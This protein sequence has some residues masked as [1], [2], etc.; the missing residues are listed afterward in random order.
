M[1]EDRIQ[2]TEQDEQEESG[3]GA[4]EEGCGADE[5]LA[6]RLRL[7]EEEWEELRFENDVQCPG[8]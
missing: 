5:A 1:K 7:M 6:T 2:E 4:L 8:G 3:T